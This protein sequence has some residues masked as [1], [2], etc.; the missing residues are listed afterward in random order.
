VI[1][2]RKALPS[3]TDVRRLDPIRDELHPLKLTDAR[4]DVPPRSLE[5]VT[6]ADGDLEERLDGLDVLRLH[7]A[8]VV[9]ERELCERPDKGVPL[10]LELEEADDL[11]GVLEAFETKLN[12]V[13]VVGLL[14]GT[15]EGGEEGHPGDFEHGT[16]VLEVR[17]G[18][19]LLGLLDAAATLLT[20]HGLEEGLKYASRARVSF[21]AKRE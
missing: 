7:L 18:V 6:L 9:E 1:G 20:K 19:V 11:D 3:T 4:Q 10:E 16:D 2:K 14:E 5:V 21:R 17:G 12:D 13:E 8:Q 15:G